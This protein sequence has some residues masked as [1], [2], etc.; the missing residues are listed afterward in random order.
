[1][2]WRGDADDVRDGS[3]EDGDDTDDGAD[4]D[5][6]GAGVGIALMLHGPRLLVNYFPPSEPLPEVQ[7]CLGHLATR[8]KWV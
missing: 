7:A 4:D 3:D 5:G 2:L 6:G 1:M 8:A